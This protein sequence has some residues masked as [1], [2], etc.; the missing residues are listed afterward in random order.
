VSLDRHVAIKVLPMPGGDPKRLARQRQ[1]AEILAHL[2]HPNVV[3]VYEVAHHNGCLYLV[4]EF[5]DGPTL[6]EF[7]AGKALAANEAAQL[8]LTFAATMQVVHDAGFLHR[9]LKPSNVLVP[10]TEQIR[11]TD[12]GLAKFRSG[13]NMLT[14]E[15]S[16]LG[17]PSYMSPEQALGGAQ[18]AGPGRMC[19]RWARSYTNC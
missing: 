10:A 5:I 3:H 4:M 14:T 19:I 13:D 12:F 15:D 8:V 18:T 6:K 2:R 16:V 17:T 9:D 1:E 7:A 11:I